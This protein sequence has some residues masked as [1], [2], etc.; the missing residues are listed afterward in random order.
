[1]LGFIHSIFD[2]LAYVIGSLSGYVDMLHAYF[3]MFLFGLK[4]VA[5]TCT[6][7]I[8]SIPLPLQALATVFISVAVARLCV[9]LGGH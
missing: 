8:W 9:N 3:S 4:Y 1:M 7:F 2:Y 6:S 5:G